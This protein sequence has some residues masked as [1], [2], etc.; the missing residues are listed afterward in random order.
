[1][2][3]DPPDLFKNCAPVVVEGHWA[4]R[5]RSSVD[6]ILIRHGA[7]YYEAAEGPNATDEVPAATR[8]GRRS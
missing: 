4:R 8:E 6:R 7:T 3:G 2:Q 1:M 5:R